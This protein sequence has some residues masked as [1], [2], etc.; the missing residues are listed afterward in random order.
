MQNWTRILN[1]HHKK[2]ILSPSPPRNFSRAD[3]QILAFYSVRKPLL[4]F[5]SL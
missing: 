3:L 4:E 5:D 2:R 1:L